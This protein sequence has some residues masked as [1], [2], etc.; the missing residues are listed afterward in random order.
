MSEREPGYYIIFDGPP[1]RE[2]GRF[3]EVEDE[4]GRSVG[5]ETGAEWVEERW[6]GL[7]STWSLGPFPKPDPKP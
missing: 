1:S 7:P 6:V 2:S 4:T 5:A 3:I